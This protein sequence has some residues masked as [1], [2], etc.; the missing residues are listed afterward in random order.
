MSETGTKKARAE[1][2]SSATTPTVSAQAKQAV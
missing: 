2:R 1:D